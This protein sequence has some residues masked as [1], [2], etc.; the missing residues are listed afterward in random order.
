MIILFIGLMKKYLIQR[1]WLPN[2]DS[3]CVRWVW[4]RW[5]NCNTEQLVSFMSRCRGKQIA[6]Q[7]FLR[8]F[9]RLKDRGATGD[10]PSG[11]VWAGI[12]SEAT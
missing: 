7:A 1:R 4:P 5:S 3:S 12:N 10:T 11:G 6:V 9:R 2:R 8:I